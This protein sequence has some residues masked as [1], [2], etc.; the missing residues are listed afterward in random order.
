MPDEITVDL[1]GMSVHEA[2][3][4]LY[5]AYK[6]IAED[7]TNTDE[8]R[9]DAKKAMRIHRAALACYLGIPY[10]APDDFPEIREAPK[11]VA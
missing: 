9:A 6:E 1:S 7:T 2:S 3:I 11:C 8:C 5:Q 10:P 4:A